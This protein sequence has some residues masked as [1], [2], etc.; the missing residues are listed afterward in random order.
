M[1][2][3]I[4]AGGKG[5]RLKPYT[6]V[7][8]KPLVPVGDQ[9]ILELVLRQLRAGGFTDVT[10][11]LGHLGQLIQAYC[12]DGSRWGLNL[13]YSFETTPLGTAG[14]LALADPPEEHFL[15]MNGDLL[16]TLDYGALLRAHA[17]SGKL[18]TV[19]V[20]EKQV[21]IDLGVLEL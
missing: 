15:A 11:A 13:R 7:F 17:A 19:T 4:L 21:P 2:A 8:P 5:S 12:G 14:P 1:R 9:P 16:T 3:V 10:L 18:V 20:F 6:T